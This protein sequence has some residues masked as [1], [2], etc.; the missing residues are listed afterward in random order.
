MRLPIR[1]ILRRALVVFLYHE[2]SD[3]PSEFN[4]LFNL[5]VCPASFSRQMDL[6]RRR[7]HVIGPRE[8][9]RGGYP[10]PA[11]LITFDD[12]NRSY[13]EV[14]LPI[15]KSKGI[16][17]VVFLNMG[18]VLGEPCWSGL[19]TY[20]QHREP[21]FVSRGGRRPTG[22]DFCRI[23]E[24]EVA[25][26][27]EGEEAADFLER[28]RTFRGPI[29][30]EDHLREAA[31]EPLVT[32]GNH[33]FNHYNATLLSGRL[34]EEY[35]KN[36]RLIEQY[37]NASRLVSYPFSRWSPQTTRMLLEEGAQAL[38]IGGGLPNFQTHGPMF[39]RLELGEGVV[40]E[41]QMDRLLLRNPL[42]ALVR[43]QLTWS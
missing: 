24:E 22:N 39:R 16:P 21:R 20:L 42:P 32:F 26:Y 8:L 3:S 43:G 15:L 38:F 14:A 23:R 11:A 19:V 9:L 35:R 13:F 4:R 30:S 36:Q 6:I 31:K 2:V 28:V 12:G 17:S 1:W 37:P 40:T 10:R 34:R 7:F 27:L 5:A 33:L 25:H 41:P 29:A 18:P